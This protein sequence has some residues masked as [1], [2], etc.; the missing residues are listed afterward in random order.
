MYVTM[1]NTGYR[2]KLNVY[3]Q[4]VHKTS[5]SS[6]ERL[7]YVQFTSCVQ[8]KIRKIQNLPGRNCFTRTKAWRV[9]LNNKIATLK[10]D[11]RANDLLQSRHIK[12][13]SLTQSNIKNTHKK[14]FLYS[15]VKYP[16][17]TS[18]FVKN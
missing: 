7:I 17:L 3:V 1:L 10:F 16:R 14:L 12:N 2:M 4:D 6:S 15:I 11:R 13:L 8:G 5:R 9:V 18:A